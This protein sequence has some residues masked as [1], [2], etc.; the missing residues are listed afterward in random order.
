MT[1]QKNHP[2]QTP[3][4]PRPTIPWKPLDRAETIDDAVRN[5]DQIIDW[6][7]RAQS[8]VGYFAVLYKRSTLGIRA[9]MQQGL[10]FDRPLMERFD[11][12]FAQ[13][14]FDALNAYFCPD[15]YDGLTLAWEVAF[16]DQ[17]RAH[18]S[19][20]Q[21]MVAGLSAH[22]MF[23]LGVATAHMVPNDMQAFEHDYKLINA[24]VATQIRGMLDVVETLSPGV[25]WI[26]RAI[27]NEVMFI[28]RLLI[29]FRKSGWLFAI[30]LAMSPDEAR[31][32]MVNQLS[33]TSAL[34]AW[35]LDPPTYGAVAPRLI[36]LIAKRESKD[37]A[38]NLRA[39]DDANFVPDRL[40]ESF[41]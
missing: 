25:L 8:T 7:I 19:M 41:L 22:I 13:R 3:A 10:F 38:A 1:T 12:V 16:L 35:Y 32:R 21:H 39:L 9:A 40:D 27:P 15:K 24:L 30:S 17:D 29:K 6:S 11:V 4:T 36:R 14:Y 20:L 37:I 18:S 2:G 33:W 34:G 26:R 28:R 31:A 5:L 23:D